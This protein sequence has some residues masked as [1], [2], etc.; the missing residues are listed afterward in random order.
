MVES[1]VIRLLLE[2]YPR[3]HP[4]V[5][6]QGEKVSEVVCIG[7][8]TTVRAATALRG[9]LMIGKDC[10]TGPEAYTGLY[11]PIGNNTAI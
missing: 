6:H 8:G 2:A 3:I 4:G 5:I 1:Q 9:P 11:S 7:S 10:D